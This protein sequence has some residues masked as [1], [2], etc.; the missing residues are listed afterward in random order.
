M[1]IYDFS[2]GIVFKT[3]GGLNKLISKINY[4]IDYVD[5]I[6]IVD[7]GPLDEY[8]NSRKLL[9]SYKKV[10]IS[11]SIGVGYEDPILPYAI[12]MCRSDWILKLQT[13]ELPNFELLRDLYK[14]VQKFRFRYSAFKIMRVEHFAPKITS[15]D[16][17]KKKETSCS[18]VSY[19]IA[20]FK[21]W[22]CSV[23]RIYSSATNS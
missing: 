18:A 16:K 10:S 13:T 22:F 15:N 7:S 21:K 17:K 12:S 2:I 1:V 23:Y 9:E 20:L 5:E 19:Q 8:M 14:I 11:R 3:H 6:V 4:L